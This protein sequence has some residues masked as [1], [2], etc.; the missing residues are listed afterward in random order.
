[1]PYAKPDLKS[2]NNSDVADYEPTRCQWLNTANKE[3]VEYHDLEWGMPVNDDQLYEALMLECF[4]AGLSWE[5]ILRKRA[6]FCLAF[7]GWNASVVASYDTDKVESLMANPGIIRH[8]GKIGAAIT[9]AR[10][11]LDIQSKYGSFEAYIRKFTGPDIIRSHQ[12]APSDVAIEISRHLKKLGMKFTGPSTIHSFL[13]ATGF[14]NA[15]EPCCFLY[16]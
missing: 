2:P 11:F 14:I 6:A 3:Y 15:H 9:N 10:I 1:M 4:Q 12:N 16:E 13:Q 7:D 8:R 5:C